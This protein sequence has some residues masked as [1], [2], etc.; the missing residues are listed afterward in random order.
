MASSPSALS[1]STAPPAPP[2]SEPALGPIA[3]LPLEL[4]TH[5]LS[6]VMDLCDHPLDRQCESQ[7]FLRVCRAFHSAYLLSEA[8]HECAVDSWSGTRRLISALK[9]GRA[10]SSKV[11]RLWVGLPLTSN[12]LVVAE[13]VGACR[14]SLRS[15]RW[16]PA[17]AMA[18]VDFEVQATLA[19]AWAGCDRME[20][21]SLGEDARSL[22]GG[23]LERYASFGPDQ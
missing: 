20:V 19:Q 16:T 13:L 15:F 6:R 9:P 21:F 5:I 4:L 8:V 2:A 12:D 18:R 7:N 10:R 23:E 11:E 1:Q 14:D 22:T 3:K 17:Y